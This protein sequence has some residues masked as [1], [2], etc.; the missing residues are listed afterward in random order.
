[1][2]SYCDILGSP[3]SSE[4]T[5]VWT[6]L[7]LC[8]FLLQHLTTGIFTGNSPK[9]Y[10]YLTLDGYLVCHGHLVQIK[11]P[12]KVRGSWQ[13]RDIY[14][15]TGNQRLMR[16]VS[17]SVIGK[18]YIQRLARM[19]CLSEALWFVQGTSSVDK[20]EKKKASFTETRVQIFCGLLMLPGSQGPRLPKKQV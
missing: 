18:D 17:N 20:K 9:P 15:W 14:H 6:H 3:V 16:L 8:Q 19:N 7:H 5:C 10:I 12:L 4:P 13:W 2:S 11:S 1:M